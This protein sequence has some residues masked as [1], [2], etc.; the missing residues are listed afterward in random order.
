MDAVHLLPCIW[1]LLL[2]DCTMLPRQ[3]VGERWLT[4]GEAVSFTWAVSLAFVSVLFQLP[5][6]EG[7]LEQKYSG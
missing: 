4:S 5:T 1:L 7:Y 3:A 6:L 2:P